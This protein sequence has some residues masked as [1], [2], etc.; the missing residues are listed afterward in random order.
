MHA[1]LEEPF[2]RW[3][4]REISTFEYLM[5]LNLLAGR[6]YNDLT[7][8]PVFPWVLTD[9][10]SEKL[11]LTDPNVFRDLSKPMG[12]LDEER[13]AEC[14]ERYATFDD[15]EIPKFHYGVCFLEISFFPPFAFFLDLLVLVSLI[16]D[17]YI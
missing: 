6:S 11:D 14:R 9:Y 1:L 17:Q 10:T 2:A 7:Q 5:E 13:L 15:P 4:Q 3:R 12:A 16:V 8:Y